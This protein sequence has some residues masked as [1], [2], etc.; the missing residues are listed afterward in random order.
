METTYM[1][2]KGN[3]L[4]FSIFSIGLILYIVFN[5]SRLTIGEIGQILGAI[6]LF[7]IP[8]ILDKFFS[9]SFAPITITLYLLFVFFAYVLGNVGRLYKSTTYFDTLMHFL[10][11]IIGAMIGLLTLIK[12]KKYQKKDVF[13]T[14]L[15]CIMMVLAISA[16]WEMLEFSMDRLFGMDTQRS[17]TGVLDTMKDIIVAFFG[18][19][20]FSIWYGYEILTNTPLLLT[21]YVDQEQAILKK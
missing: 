12:F 14:I 13:F 3:Y 7:S 4:L 9:I 8:F 6:V 17:G 5:F 21:R 2:K 20:L 18:S 16:C 11:G 10:T 1:N 19:I 15:F